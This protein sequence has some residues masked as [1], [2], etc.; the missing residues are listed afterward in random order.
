MII[1]FI[2]CQLYYCR[3]APYNWIHNSNFEELCAV[4][5]SYVVH[6]NSEL[7]ARSGN[8]QGVCLSC[9]NIDYSHFEILEDRASIKIFNITKHF[10]RPNLRM[11]F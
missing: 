6:S 5:S 11:S 3:R 4:S 7:V 10:I 8:T 2:L 9:L 1:I